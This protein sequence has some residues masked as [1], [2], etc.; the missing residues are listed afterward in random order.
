MQNGMWRLCALLKLLAALRQ[1]AGYLL[2]AALSNPV[3][4]TN[5]VGNLRALSICRVHPPTCNGNTREIPWYRRVL[6][7]VEKLPRLSTAHQ[8]S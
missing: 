3:G 1:I 6:L 7:L 8:A 4:N 2:V 5:D